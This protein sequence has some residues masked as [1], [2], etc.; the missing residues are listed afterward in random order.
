MLA[1]LLA[2]SLET[3]VLPVDEIAPL[4]TPAVQSVQVDCAPLGPGAYWAAV[5]ASRMP[6]A[7]SPAP[8]TWLDVPANVLPWTYGRVVTAEAPVFETPEAALANTPARSLGT[9]FIFVNLV[10]GLQAGDLSLFQIRSGEYIRAVDVA[11]IEATRFQGV[12]I[13]ALPERPFGWVVR[14]VRPSP[15]PG[16]AADTSVRRIGR[17]NLIQIYGTVLV[18][19]WN[20]YQVGPGQWIEQR[21]VSVVNLNPVPAGVSGRWIQVDLY[22]QTLVAYEGATPVYATLVSSGLDKWRTEPGLF[23]VYARLKADR[24]S[25]AY[26]P[27]RS[28]YYALEMVPWVMYFDGDRALHGEYWHDGLGFKRSHGCVNLSP[29]DSRW[30][31]DWSDIGTWVWVYDPSDGGTHADTSSAEGP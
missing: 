31:F 30:L 8:V 5:A 10:E 28:D 4:C 29:A 22:E 14:A 6:G 18:D 11:P 16:V 20:W 21:N 7:E 13:T 17:G 24:M 27:D 15:L 23:Q 19:G 26:A 3:N 2:W 9:G 12:S 1:L 25:G